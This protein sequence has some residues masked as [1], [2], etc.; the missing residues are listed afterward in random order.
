[1][2]YKLTP[3]G[4]ETVLHDFIGASDGSHPTNLAV[5]SVVREYAKLA[6][7]DNLARMIC[8]ERVPDSAILFLAR[9]MPIS[10]R[11]RRGFWHDY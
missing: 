2:L 6:A 4:K 1:V 11:R 10:H 3:N 7:I 8:A 5:W 9:R